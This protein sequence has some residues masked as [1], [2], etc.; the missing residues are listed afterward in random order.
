MKKI[1]RHVF[2]C[3][4]VDAYRDELNETIEFLNDD[5]ISASKVN[6]ESFDLGR[7]T[8][9]TLR[10]LASYSI[11]PN[12]EQSLSKQ[13]QTLV[14]WQDISK[15]FYTL[16]Y[17]AG[18]QVKIRLQGEYYQHKGIAYSSYMDF[19]IWLNT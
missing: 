1:E 12:K 3:L 10:H 8:S 7:L 11:L 18:Q 14:L 16:A 2:D 6:T 17:G 13:S 5:V 4:E 15:A 19:P 9:S